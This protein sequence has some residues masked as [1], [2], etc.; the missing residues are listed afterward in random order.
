MNMDPTERKYAFLTDG[1]D[2]EGAADDDSDSISE[3]EH[4]TRVDRMAE[5]I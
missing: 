1:A 3:D 5:E 2:L 4:V